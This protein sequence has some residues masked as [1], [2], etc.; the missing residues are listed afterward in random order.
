MIYN[1]RRCTD[2]G[3]LRKTKN[4]NSDYNRY[5]G[6]KQ[7]LKE[8]P[9]LQLRPNTRSLCPSCLEELSIWLRDKDAHVKRAP[10]KPAIAAKQPGYSN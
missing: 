5:Q 7:A 9:I 3:V 6:L 2:S 1:C 8:S 10:A 4:R